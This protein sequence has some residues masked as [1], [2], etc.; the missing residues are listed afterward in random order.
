MYCHELAGRFCSPST[1]SCKRMV[2]KESSPSSS[3][4][5]LFEGKF[6]ALVDRLVVLSTVKLKMFVLRKRYFDGHKY[7]LR[8]AL[9]SRA[10]ATREVDWL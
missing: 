3:P 10:A 5:M 7:V 8:E 4:A 6:Q 2:E 9:S 1:K